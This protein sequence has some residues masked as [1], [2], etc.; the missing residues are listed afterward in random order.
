M[1]CAMICLRCKQRGER[2]SRQVARDGGLRFSSKR[3]R[4]FAAKAAEVK[5]RAGRCIGELMEEDRKPGRLARQMAPAQEEKSFHPFVL[6]RTACPLSRPHA[7]KA[8]LQKPLALQS[9]RPRTFQDRLL[10]ELSIGKT[11]IRWSA[12]TTMPPG[13]CRRRSNTGDHQGPGPRRRNPRR[14][15][16]RARR[17]RNRGRSTKKAAA[18]TMS[19]PF[20]AKPPC[21]TSCLANRNHPRKRQA[22]PFTAPPP[23]RRPSRQGKMP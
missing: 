3:I 18:K 10:G 12:V 21:C 11:R 23:C 14:H 17:R 1:P 2:Y 15:C 4:I 8:Y 13:T 16:R 19:R 22:G 7:Q 5:K 9:N 6:S 20:I